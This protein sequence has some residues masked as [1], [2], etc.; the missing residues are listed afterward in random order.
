[1]MLC[2]RRALLRAIAITSFVLAGCGSSDP[3]FVAT[4][5][6]A[7]P[8]P[9][10][11]VPALQSIVRTRMAEMTVPGAIVL[12]KSPTMGNW[13][14]AFG[15]RDLGKTQQITTDD[16]FRIGS[17]T[18]TMTGTVVLQLVEEGLV[19]L[20]DPIG[21]YVDGVPNG[22]LI[23]VENLLM[24]RSGLPNYT[25]TLYLNQQLD[26]NP[27]RAWLPSELLALAFA[28]DIINPDTEYEYSNTNTVLLGLL[29]EDVTGEVAED[30][31]SERI[32]AP[33]GLTH[34]SLPLRDDVSLPLPHPRGYMYSTNVA[35][36]DS[37][38]LSP[39]EQAAALAGTLL[40]TDQTD[41]NISWTWTAGSGISNVEE[42]GLYAR[43]LVRG[44][45]LSPEMHAARMESPIP[46]DPN[47]PE[48]NAYGW[49]F[50]RMGRAYGHTGSAPGF[51]SY[52]G[53]V[54]E[55]DLTVIVF[56][57]LSDSPAGE[58]P[59]VKIADEILQSIYRQATGPDDFSEFDDK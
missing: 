22:D 46:I 25:K 27:S 6:A 34:T 58:P 33:L 13:S 10:A 42:L 21:D 53:H 16:H 18:K 29:I 45:Y 40:P 56:T 43:A 24:M 55:E 20:K 51:N 15:Y 26:D 38:V 5:P 31:I 4:G 47:A 41:A 57:N 11:Y 54:P 1:M 19:A 17:N 35:T 39:Q 32:F 8:G 2:S 23:T 30:V 9:P 59:A 52:M 37:S 48:K 14:E 3:N 49:G 28:G 44:T 7:N 36:V 12:V 50:A